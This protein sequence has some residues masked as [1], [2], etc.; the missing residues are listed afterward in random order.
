MS[1]QVRAQDW[2]FAI[3]GMSCVK[4][5]RKVQDV[6]HRFQSI[7]DIRVDFE[8]HLLTTSCDDTFV[9]SDFEKAIQDAGF[10]TRMLSREESE[11]QRKGWNPL[12]VRLGVAGAC[13]GNI[14]LLAIANYSGAEV[15]ELGFLFSWVSFRVLS[16]RD[17]LLLL[18]FLSEFVGGFDPSKSL[19]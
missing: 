8:R 6:A 13:T 12:L 18:G 16:T 11:T 3:E 15:S 5:I 10:S 4:C 1:H 2:S 9:P 19:G 14:M 17:Y 7:Q